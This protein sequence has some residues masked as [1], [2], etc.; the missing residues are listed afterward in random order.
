MST[1]TAQWTVDNWSR[2]QLIT[3]NCQLSSLYHRKRERF[4]ALCDKLTAS[5]ALIASTA[6]LSE[7]LPTAEYKAMAGAVV[8]AVTLPGIVFGWSDRARAHALL[9][10]RFV[11]LESEVV[12]AGAM[13]S[14]QL[15]IAEAKGISIGA[16]EPPQLSALTRLCQNEL[17]NAKGI[18]TKTLPFW[19]RW[20]AHFLDLPKA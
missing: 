11:A 1:E 2:R 6:A 15:D 4:F 3:Y 8:A 10:A 19:E 20:L 5:A 17:G 7:Y 18:P 9:A 16:D 14:A 13:N 12:A